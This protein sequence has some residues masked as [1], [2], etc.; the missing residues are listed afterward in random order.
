MQRRLQLYLAA[1]M[2]LLLGALVA[3]YVQSSTGLHAL[4]LIEQVNQRANHLDYLYK[5][6]LD[7]E[8][9]TRGYLLTRDPSFLLP[10]EKALPE[11]LE[12]VIAIE[13]EGSGNPE[14]RMAT[15]QLI[16]KASGLLESLDITAEQSQVNPTLQ[17]HWLDHGRAVMSAYRLQH[18]DVKAMLM[19]DNQRLVEDSARS[20][21][22]AKISAVALAIASLML[23]L[24]A[25]SSNQK[26]Q[27][28]RDQITGLLL[29]KNTHLEQEV[30]SQTQELTSLATYLTT[31]RE[32]EKQ[33]LARELHDELGALLTA[34]QLDADWIERKLPADTLALIMQR[35]ARLR[36]SLTSGIMLKRRII[37]D[38]RPAL[39]HDLGL[40]EALNSLG[41]ELRQGLEVDLEMELPQEEPSLDDAVSL[42]LFRIVQEAFTNIQ[43][44]AH[45]KHVGLALRLNE[46]SIELSIKDDGVG[47]DL[48]SPKLAR[49]GLAG[50]KHRVFTHRGSLD[51]KSSLGAG[52]AIWV[53]IPIRSIENRNQP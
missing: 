29:N 21:R 31:V 10:R 30:L 41:E 43:K 18:S 38:L 46:S 45:A 53:T 40:L 28:L 42:S 25:I 15:A 12:T 37:D 16:E 49:H 47:F 13:Q 27:A 32:K 44:Y 23:L 7:S 24:L 26:Q 3:N 36:Q 35:L 5:L 22:N 11:I 33:H 6:L 8:T 52:V 34:A 17:K 51:L 2:A 50:I 9:A 1:G 19:A 14:L 4:K 39:L 20:F 48:N